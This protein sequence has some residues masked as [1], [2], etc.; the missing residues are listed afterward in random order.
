MSKKTSAAIV[1]LAGNHLNLTVE[2]AAKIPLI[3]LVDII[4]KLSGSLVA[5]ETIGKGKN[6]K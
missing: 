4:K 1:K 2:E 5:Q 3:K 6:D